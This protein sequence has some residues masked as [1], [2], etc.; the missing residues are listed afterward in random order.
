MPRKL[1]LLQHTTPG[2]KQYE[3]LKL[4]CKKTRHEFL[5]SGKFSNE[6]VHMAHTHT[7]I[8]TTPYNFW[9]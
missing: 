8:W 5:A 9:K 7:H 3:F 6:A 4:M 2:D 1:Q